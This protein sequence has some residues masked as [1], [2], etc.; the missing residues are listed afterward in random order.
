MVLFG[1]R[2]KKKKDLDTGGSNGDSV[3]PSISHDADPERM[4]AYEPF[5]I[6]SGTISVVN[7]RFLGYRFNRSSQVKGMT[8]GL[9]MFSN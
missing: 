3:V 7:E 5:Y 1:C 6:S 8:L 9:M 4:D 2:W